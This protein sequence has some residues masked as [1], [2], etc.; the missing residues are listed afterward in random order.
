MSLDD[1]K[2]PEGEDPGGIVLIHIKDRDTYYIIEG[3]EHMHEMML[4]D[5][6][7]PKPVRCVGFETIIELNAFT[8]GTANLSDLWGINPEIIKRL[9]RDKHLLEIDAPRD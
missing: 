9:R 3:S 7:F 8:D 2:Q 6:S 1:A 5:G 4:V